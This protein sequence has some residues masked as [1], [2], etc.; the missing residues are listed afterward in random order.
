MGASVRGILLAGAVSLVRKAI[1][2]GD[3]LREHVE[4][5]L[6]G[7]DHAFL[8]EKVDPAEWYPVV[9]LGHYLDVLADLAGGDRR[10]ALMALGRDAADMT[11]HSGE[12]GQLA[13]DRT[14]SE[15]PSEVLRYGRLVTTVITHFYDFSRMSFGPH[16]AEPEAFQIDWYDVGDLPESNRL[17]AEGFIDRVAEYASAM[18]LA[19]ASDRPSPD[20]IEVTIRQA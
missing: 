7:P 1:R 20:H 4:A 3:L 2:E 18:P 9:T 14:V 16:P 6:E 19:V 13:R 8:D 11:A 17:C 10:E 5:R 12:Y 15:R